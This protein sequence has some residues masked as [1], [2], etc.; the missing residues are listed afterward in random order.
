M[1]F[2]CASSAERL[3]ADSGGRLSAALLFGGFGITIMNLFRTNVTAFPGATTTITQ[4]DWQEHC[5]NHDIT[6]FLN[7][8]LYEFRVKNI[9]G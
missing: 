4:K 7:G 6:F 9:G 1:E 3:S 5:A 8:Q 2:T